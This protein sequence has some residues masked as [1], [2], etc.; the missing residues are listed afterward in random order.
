DDDAWPR[1][2][3][4]EPSLNDYSGWQVFAGDE[5]AGWAQDQANARAVSVKD[6]L[7]RFP[8]LESIF[9]DTTVGEWQWSDEALEY[10]RELEGFEVGQEV[11]EIGRREIRGHA[12]VVAAA[13]GAKAPRERG[14]AAVV[15]E[16]RAPAEADEPRHLEVAAGAD[17]GGHVV[18]HLGPEVAAPA[19][20]A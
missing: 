13:T 11:G 8:V 6:I 5:P 14:R 1:R 15:Q 18:G 12:V 16:G 4:R 10:S 19:A 2:L 7:E 20:H 9:G 17:V 3:V